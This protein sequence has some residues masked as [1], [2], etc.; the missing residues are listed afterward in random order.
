MMF[1]CCFLNNYIIN[2]ISFVGRNKIDKN[3]KKIS[4]GITLHPEI[5]K[6]LETI[7]EKEGMSKS[8][9]IEYILKEKFKNNNNE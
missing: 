8:G 9:L 5:A 2:Y 7:S 6:L 1:L 4:F 3:V